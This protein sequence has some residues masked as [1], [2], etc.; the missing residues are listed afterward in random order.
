MLSQRGAAL[1]P[2]SRQESITIKIGLSGFRAFVFFGF[3]RKIRR[4]CP[5]KIDPQTSV[6]DVARRRRGSGPSYS[7]SA[8][9]F[10]LEKALPIIFWS[11]RTKKRFCDRHKIL[12]V[13]V[14]RLVYTCVVPITVGF[15]LLKLTCM[16]MVPAWFQQE[17][18]SVFSASIVGLVLGGY[19]P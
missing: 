14:H 1:R 6:I 12:R 8:G 15:F 7:D 4:F 17:V 5:A 3:F 16:K 9:S 13:P 19:C 10:T 2:L 18:P 11:S